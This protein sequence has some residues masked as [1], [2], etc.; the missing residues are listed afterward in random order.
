MLQ[1]SINRIPKLDLKLEQYR[2]NDNITLIPIK[3]YGKYQAHH[4]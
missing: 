3:V 2:K 4:S 1:N